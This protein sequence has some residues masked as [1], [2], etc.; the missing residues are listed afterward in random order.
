M[1]SQIIRKIYV[2]NSRQIIVS[3][4]YLYMFVGVFSA[5]PERKQDENE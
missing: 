2:S 4:Q 5:Q 1:P 3:V